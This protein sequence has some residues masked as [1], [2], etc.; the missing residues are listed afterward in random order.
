MVKARFA[1]H[2]S[3]NSIFA[4]HRE[5]ERRVLPLF[6]EQTVYRLL[7]EHEQRAPLINFFKSLFNLNFC[8]LFL[9][10]SSSLVRPRVSLLWILAFVKASLVETFI[11]LSS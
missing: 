4:R 5:F 8:E 7:L 3:I 2:R 11:N 6:A 10:H 9:F 1:A